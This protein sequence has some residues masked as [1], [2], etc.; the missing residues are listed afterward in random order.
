MHALD[1]LQFDCSWC[2]FNFKNLFSQTLAKY[3]GVKLF[4]L[5][6]Q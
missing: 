4:P 5:N 3:S 6:S 1:I 2:L